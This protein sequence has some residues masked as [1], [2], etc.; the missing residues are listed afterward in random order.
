MNKEVVITIRATLP[1]KQEL[2]EYAEMLGMSLS[3]YMIM[4]GLNL[5]EESENE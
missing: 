4:R 1:D 5:D 3:A 2:Q